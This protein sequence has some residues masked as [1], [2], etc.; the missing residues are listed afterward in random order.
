[1]ILYSVIH[2]VCLNN[3]IILL[4]IPNSVDSDSAMSA[5]DENDSSAIND[6]SKIHLNFYESSIELWRIEEKCRCKY[7]NFSIK[8]QFFA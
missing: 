2:F 5:N 4:L 1:M 8:Y 3:I 6:L 7:F